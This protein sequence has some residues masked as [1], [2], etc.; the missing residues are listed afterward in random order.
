MAILLRKKTDAEVSAP[1]NASRVTLYV[2]S[3][4]NPKIKDSTN[5]VASAMSV[6]GGPLA[7]DNQGS[8][9]STESGKSKLY[10]KDVSSNSEFFVLDGAGNEVQVTSAGALAV[11]GGDPSTWF[12]NGQTYE[13]VIDYTGSSGA[14]TTDTGLVI[15]N[16]NYQLLTIYL[17]N[18]YYGSGGENGVGWTQYHTAWG[19][20]P[21]PPF[22]FIPIGTNS[23][24][25]TTVIYTGLLVNPNGTLEVTI[26]SG[27]SIV[28]SVLISVYSSTVSFA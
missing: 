6:T 21:T 11:A 18:N 1:S 17:Q 16:T 26:N 27:S 15:P 2:D 28:G 23:S 24:S 14:D 7:L 20:A 22:A 5:S 4:G 25:N 3:D 13:H 19:T 10:A 8:A 12:T 9:P